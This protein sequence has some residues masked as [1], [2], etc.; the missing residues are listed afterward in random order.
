MVYVALGAFVLLV[1]CLTWFSYR[2]GQTMNGCCAPADPRDDLRMR[3][4]F[5]DDNPD[6]SAQQAP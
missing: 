4:A 2:H 5:D 1:G 6:P 3:A